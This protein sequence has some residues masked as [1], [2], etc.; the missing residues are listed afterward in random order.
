M[1]IISNMEVSQQH[2]QT[3]NFREKKP[4]QNVTLQTSE[5]T[6]TTL[7]INSDTDSMLTPV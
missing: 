2:E 7:K 4:M 1:G 3:L 5:E 6:V